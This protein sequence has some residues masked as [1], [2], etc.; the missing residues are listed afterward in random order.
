M[1]DFVDLSNFDPDAIPEG[2]II[3]DGSEVLIRVTRISKAEDKNG[4]PYLMPWYEDP[5]NVNVE[6]FSDYLPLPTNEDTEKEKG[7][8]L[9]NLKSF[10]ECFDIPLFNGEFNLE[11]AKGKTGW[12]IVG[13]GKNKEGKVNNRPKKYLANHA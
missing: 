12:M 5:E 3:E 10:A 6:D 11:D 2:E 4:T 7:R 1:S 13:L 9:R 8:K